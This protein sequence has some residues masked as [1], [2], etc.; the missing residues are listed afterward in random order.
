MPTKKESENLVNQSMALDRFLSTL[1]KSVAK[2]QTALQQYYTED[3]QGRN[4]AV[5]YTIPSVSLEIKLNFTTSE[6]KGISFFFK[7]TKETTTEVFSSM[8]LNLSAIPNPQHQ[9][10]QTTYKV[11]AGDTLKVIAN[12]LNVSMKDLLK[13]NPDKIPDPNNIPQGILLNILLE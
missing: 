8:K 6:E 3:E 13:W 12:K 9:S 11:K 4:S 10:A 2:G 7:K 5:A 1:V